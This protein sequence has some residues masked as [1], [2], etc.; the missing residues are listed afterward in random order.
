MNGKALA[1]IAVGSVFLWSGIKGWS[2]L[3]TIGDI[4]QGG[5]SKTGK[6]ITPLTTGGI[7]SAIGI[8]VVGGSGLGGE[9]AAEGQRWIG[10][11]YRYAGAPG[12][13][14]SGFWDCSSFVN[15][16]CAV[17]MGLPIPGYAAGKWQGQNHGP[18]TF[19][20]AIWPGIKGVSRSE[21]Q[22]GDIIVYQKGAS[23]H[24]GIAIS[25][26]MMVHAPNPKAGTVISEIDGE[27][28]PVIRTARYPS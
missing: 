27:S 25:N 23:G 4:I 13:D 1:A 28:K 5:P 22:A 17:K 20:W 14:G 6:R 19:Q 15:F 3:A 2:V 9:I 16:V 18:T 24:M 26:T 11:P 12:P 8:G 10:H 7:D 21:V